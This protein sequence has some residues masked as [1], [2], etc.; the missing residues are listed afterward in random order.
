[1]KNINEYQRGKFRKDRQVAFKLPVD[2][3]YKLE[4]LAYQYAGGNL[5]NLLRLIY[6]EWKEKH[7][8]KQK[9]SVE[10]GKTKS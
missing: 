2:E 5:S 4:E 6:F 9:N 8:A 7:D 1:M 10:S 3:F